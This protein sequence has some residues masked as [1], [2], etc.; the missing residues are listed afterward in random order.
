M[1]QQLKEINLLKEDKIADCIGQ[2]VQDYV[3][4]NDMVD[5]SYD[6]QAAYFRA[7]MDYAVAGCKHLFHMGNDE[8]LTKG[9]NQ[10]VSKSPYGKITIK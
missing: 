9:N 4:A 8:P 7:A 5:M 2:G 3:D 1:R 6:G 10:T